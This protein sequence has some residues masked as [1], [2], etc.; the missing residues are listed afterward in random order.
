MSRLDRLCAI[1]AAAGHDVGHTGQGNAFHV[2]TESMLAMRYNDKAVLEQ[3]HCAL[4]FH[5][6]KQP[7]NNFLIRLSSDEKKYVRMTVIAMILSTDMSKHN[8]HLLQLK[9][10]VDIFK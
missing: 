1:I 5:L 8:K 7:Q 4:V 10:F 2:A 6:L 3:H 9:E